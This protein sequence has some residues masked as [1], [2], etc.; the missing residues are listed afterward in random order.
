MPIADLD[1]RRQLSVVIHT[2]ASLLAMK[3]LLI[4]GGQEIGT[5]PAD[6]DCRKYHTEILVL[7]PGV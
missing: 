3:G 2:P 5:A 1:I 7:L 6:P 4:H